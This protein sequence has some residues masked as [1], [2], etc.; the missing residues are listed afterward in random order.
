MK[1]ID[2]F[3]LLLISTIALSSG[4]FKDIYI[5]YNGNRTLFK[6]LLDKHKSVSIHLRM[7]R[8][9]LGQKTAHVGYENHM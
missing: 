5:L 8:H 3:F 4:C 6:D 2:K 7:S 9:S 1:A